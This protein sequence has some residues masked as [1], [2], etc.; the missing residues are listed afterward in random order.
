MRNWTKEGI[1]RNI[2]PLNLDIQ[3]NV[4]DIGNVRELHL[5]VSTLA[6]ECR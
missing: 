2:P 1:K 5:V 3:R 6:K 4:I